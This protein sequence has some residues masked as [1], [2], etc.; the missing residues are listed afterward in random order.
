MVVKVGIQNK[1]LEA[2]AMGIP[3]VSTSGGVSALSA[4]AGEQVLV[5]DD[6]AEFAGH[7]NLLLRDR[8]RA[9]GLGRAGRCYVETFHRWDVAAR[10]LEDEYRAA[11]HQR[12]GGAVA[13]ITA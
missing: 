2:M 7:L 9:C 13:A 4:R 11:I 10:L 12:N 6:P 3:C 8:E 5:A 1:L